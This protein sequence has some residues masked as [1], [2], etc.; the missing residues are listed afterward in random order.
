MKTSNK[1]ILAATVVVFAYLVVSDFALKAEY[2]TGNY[3]KE[4]YAMDD[5]ALKS[6]T[7]IQNNAGNMIDIQIIRGDKFEVFMREGVKDRVTISQ[8][9]DT[10]FIDNNGQ[11]EGIVYGAIT[12]KCP[13]FN[14]LIVNADTSG[15]NTTNLLNNVFG[16]NQPSLT[17]RATKWSYIQLAGNNFTQLDARMDGENSHL[18]INKNNSIGA[19]NFEMLGKS[20]LELVYPIINKVSYKVSDSAKLIISGSLGRKLQQ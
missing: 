6:F 14:N 10:V 19:A 9:N 4:H 20:E 3:K 8:K 11:H 15:G 5:I 18:L 12:I 16:F 7:T 2:A 1:L 17:I 13:Y